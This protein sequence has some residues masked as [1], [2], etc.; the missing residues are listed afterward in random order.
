M[1]FFGLKIKLVFI[2]IVHMNIKI[3]FNAVSFHVLREI[4]I[5]FEIIKM[6]SILNIS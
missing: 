5:D 1:Q 2:M 4:Q 6:K 3:E